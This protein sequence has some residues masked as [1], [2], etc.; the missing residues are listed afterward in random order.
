[1]N[2][3]NDILV[4]TYITVLTWVVLG[5]YSI[6]CFKCSRWDCSF[7]VILQTSLCKCGQNI[8]LGL[9]C[10]PENGMSCHYRTKI[11]ILDSKIWLR[12]SHRKLYARFSFQKACVIYQN[13]NFSYSCVIA[14]SAFCFLKSRF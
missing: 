4:M 1:M 12:L 14:R 2:Q 10:D 11:V 7:S 6:R 13:H 3:G 5:G 8:D 9:M